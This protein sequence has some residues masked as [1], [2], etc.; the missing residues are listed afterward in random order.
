MLFSIVSFALVLSG[1]LASAQGTNSWHYSETDN[2][3]IDSSLHL[4]VAFDESIHYLRNVGFDKF[5]DIDC[6]QYEA[7]RVPHVYTPN[8]TGAQRFVF[9]KQYGNTYTLRPLMAQNLAITLPQYVSNQQ[10][11]LQ[12]ESYDD[13]RLFSNRIAFIAASNVS[14]E[15][16]MKTMAGQGDLYVGAEDT[17]YHGLYASELPSDPAQRQRFIWRIEDSDHI[18]INESRTLSFLGNE[19]KRFLFTPRHSCLYRMIK[20]NL[21]IT[22]T[23]RDNSDHSVLLT[24]NSSSVYLDLD[25]SK[26]YEFILS[27][28]SAQ[29][30]SLL[31]YIVPRL[32]CNTYAV[33]D[34]Y[35]NKFDFPSY[36]ISAFDSLENNG[37]YPIM[38][39]NL[40]KTYFLTPSLFQQGSII[41]MA[42]SQFSF[43]DGH[44]N[45]GG[46]WAYNG[47]SSTW[48]EYFT[49]QDIPDSFSSNQLFGWMSCHGAELSQI[50]GYYSSLARE[51][52]VRGTSNSSFGYSDDVNTAMC[53]YSVSRMYTYLEDNVNAVN[54]IFNAREDTKSQYW[55]WYI[56]GYNQTFWNPIL[57]SRQNGVIR[58]C[59]VN[60]SNPVWNNDN[61]GYLE[62]SPSPLEL[63]TLD[64]VHN[65]DG[66]MNCSLRGEVRSFLNYDGILTTALSGSEHI[67]YKTIMRAKEWREAQNI[68]RDKCVAII[69][70]GNGSYHIYGVIMP[71]LLSD[72]ITKTKVISLET[73]QEIDPF[74]FS[75]LVREKMFHTK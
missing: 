21:S 67:P 24:S 17:S 20:S 49:F 41:S 56:F 70:S 15:Y 11:Q 37:I 33:Y 40:S 8:Y 54:V 27:N 61:G 19:T 50:N 42:K 39:A 74:L 30:N 52:V 6:A 73:G 9:E 35:N 46:A 26:T 18:N 72:P 23:L 64:L 75:S 4:N 5:L 7:G 58:Y 13:F 53:A 43:F 2:G 65:R 44:G 36:A 69:V 1:A 51:T 38:K 66:T 68:E 3:P 14:G 71:Q 29:Q 34:Y 45:P 16:Y 63:E 31:F 12:N 32:I 60:T 25:K 57:Y 55:L 28:T 10:L 59:V 62:S 22:L 47:P 48:A